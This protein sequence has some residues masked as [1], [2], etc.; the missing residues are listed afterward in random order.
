MP[1]GEGDGDLVE[2]WERGPHELIGWAPPCPP[3][4]E[5]LRE[6]FA[7]FLSGLSPL[8]REFSR[9]LAAFDQARKEAEVVTASALAETYAG[10]LPELEGIHKAAR[11][12]KVRLALTR[13][14]RPAPASSNSQKIH[15]AAAPRAH[16]K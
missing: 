2:S 6:L 11:L 7:R 13:G 14:K 12:S 10:L 16:R 1:R 8:P 4:R 3:D 9:A 5:T 15:K